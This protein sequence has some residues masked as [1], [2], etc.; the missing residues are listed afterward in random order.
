[1]EAAK[2]R[3]WVSE[4]GMEGGQAEERHFVWLTQIYKLKTYKTKTYKMGPFIVASSI[5][6]VFT[7]LRSSFY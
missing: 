3:E 4:M 2:K 7:T 5:C 1:M 6:L